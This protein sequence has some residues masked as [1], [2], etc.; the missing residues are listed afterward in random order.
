MRRTAILQ[1][2]N[3]A[4]NVIQ[5]AIGVLMARILQPELFGIY[6]LALGMAGITSLIIGM[7]IQ[8]AVSSL[9]GRA[10]AQK[11]SQE[12]ENILGFMVKATFLA[13]LLVLVVAAFLPKIASHLYGNSWVG[14]YAAI[15]IVAV[16]FSSF[17]YTIAY[18]S[19]QVTGRVKALAILLVSDQS[20]RYGLSLLGLLLGWGVLGIVSG[21]LFGALIV[22]T[23]CA[24]WYAKAVREEVVFPV[25][26]R[27][28]VVATKIKLR[29]Y[30]RFTFWVALD[31]NMGNVYMALPV[32]L[33]GIYASSSEVAFFKL[34]FGYLNL[35]LSLLGPI[36]ILLNVEF[37]KMQIEDRTRLRHN[38]WKVSL[39]SLGF[40][41]LITGGALLVSPWVFK[42]LYGQSFL[43]SVKYIFGLFFY[44]ALM[45]I[46]VGLGPMWRAMNKVKI[47]ILI[48]SLILATGIPLGLWL[49]KSYS[50]WGSVIM[51]TAWFGLSHLISFF[52]LFKKLNT[53]AQ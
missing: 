28:I 49:I 22:F 34:A 3:T 7:G 44:G 53:Y 14:I 40:S 2:G 29:K 19:F 11:D 24:F 51:V 16:V 48:N 52:Y 9:L 23:L 35:A 45:G 32:I 26:R 10:Y 38:F 1:V 30:F 4:G 37:P 8:E 21:H 50:L 12:M 39:Y 15:V 5:A 43:P 20:L 27:L 31:R 13:A 17:F 47:S 18:S 33:T 46:G 6:A 25:L 42:I 41:T 36:S